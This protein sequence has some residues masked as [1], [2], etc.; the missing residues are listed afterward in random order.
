MVVAS[1]NPA[2]VEDIAEAL[3]HFP[4]ALT[5]EAHYTVGGLGSLVCE[6]AA[7]RALNCRIVRCGINDPPAVATGSSDYLNHLHGLSARALVETAW[8]TLTVGELAQ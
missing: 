7:E 2:P 1:V 8:R 6:I 3:S 4:A 5:V